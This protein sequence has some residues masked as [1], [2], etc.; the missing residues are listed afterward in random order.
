MPKAKKPNRPEVSDLAREDVDVTL[1]LVRDDKGNATGELTDTFSRFV[2]ADRNGIA[3][4]STSVDNFNQ[5]LADVDPK[6][7][8]FKRLVWP[9]KK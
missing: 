7:L 8:R 1:G 9:T 3:E 5:R 2:P 4:V 6:S